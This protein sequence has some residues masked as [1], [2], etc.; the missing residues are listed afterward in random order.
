MPKKKSF[1]LRMFNKVRPVVCP[2]NTTPCFV[3]HPEL[4]GIPAR[5]LPFWT[6]LTPKSYARQSKDCPVF[7]ARLRND[8]IAW[9]KEENKN[10]Y[11]H[12]KTFFD[13]IIFTYKLARLRKDQIALLNKELDKY[14]T[15]EKLFDALIAG[16]YNIKDT[17]LCQPKN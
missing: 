16:Y 13:S 2:H 8:Q 7:L 3:C 10:G 11:E 4:K 9:L 1:T 12:W 14:G 5:K 17:D 6:V 15:F